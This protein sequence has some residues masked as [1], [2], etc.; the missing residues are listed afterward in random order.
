MSY[1]WKL[2][3][4]NG[5]KIM[6]KVWEEDP[7]DEIEYLQK[8]ITELKECVDS[9]T[10]KDSYYEEFIEMKNKYIKELKE[11]NE[12]KDAALNNLAKKI[13]KLKEENEEYWSR[14]KL[15]GYFICDGCGEIG[16]D[17]DDDYGKCEECYLKEQE[18]ADVLMDEMSNCEK[19]ENANK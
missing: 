4:E 12:K 19:L 14:L 17:W 3:E 8:E 5:E 18:E 11:E 9:M 1:I 7:N 15:N 16:H 2:A 6:E 13:L 10:E